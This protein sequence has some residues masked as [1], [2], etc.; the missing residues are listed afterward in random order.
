AAGSAAAVLA[1][2]QMATY[3]VGDTVTHLDDGDIVRL[4]PG[5]ITIQHRDAD[6]TPAT[7][8]RAAVVVATARQQP[9]DKAG[10][11]HYMIKEIHETPAAA[12]TA[13]ATP[14]GQFQHIL[15]TGRD[16][17]VALVGAG[18]AYYIAHLGQYH[19]MELAGLSAHA[20]PSDEAEYLAPAASGDTLIAISQSGET[21]DT[22]EVCRQAIDRG[23]TVVSISN[24]PDSTQE[25]LAA[26]RIQQGSGPEICVLSTKSIISQAVILS[27]LALEHGHDTRAL[28]DQR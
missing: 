21:F 25:R 7:V 15:P 12:A 13:R 28:T 8:A 11:P 4:T 6:G 18:S 14:A 16:W 23:A 5:D 17:R 1:S 20:Y 22:L 3:G 2:D 9:P 19:L 26:A 27:R 24:V 10:H